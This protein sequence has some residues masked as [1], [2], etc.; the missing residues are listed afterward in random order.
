MHGGGGGGGPGGGGG[1]GGGG[2][3]PGGFGGGPG[4]GGPGGFGGGPG[5]FHGGPGGPGGFGG[6]GGPGGFGGALAF[7]L[8]PS[9]FHRPPPPGISPIEFALL[10]PI[11]FGYDEEGEYEKLVKEETKDRRKY[12]Y[13]NIF[14]DHGGF[15]ES[16]FPC[17]FPIKQYYMK[18]KNPAVYKKTMDQKMPEPIFVERTFTESESCCCPYVDESRR[19]YP[20]KE[21]VKFAQKKWDDYVP[22][23]QGV[24]GPQGNMNYPREEPNGGQGPLYPSNAYPTDG[25]VGQND[26]QAV[27]LRKEYAKANNYE[28]PAN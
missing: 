14:V 10:P 17:M 7:C 15:L 28:Y 6:P 18:M 13:F 21:W 9:I 12:L 22:P 20:I 4:G 2:G 19:A 1:F 26:P 11:Y 3:G 24:P 23:N 16:L 8:I 27:P 25:Y 5:G